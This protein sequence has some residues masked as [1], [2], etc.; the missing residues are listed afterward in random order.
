M[1]MSENSMAND[2]RPPDEVE[3]KKTYIVQCIKCSQKILMKELK[4]GYSGSCSCGLCFYS[5]KPFY[6]LF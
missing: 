5:S 4:N 3:V 2:K 6:P 1:A